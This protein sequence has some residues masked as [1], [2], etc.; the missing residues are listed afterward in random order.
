MG[1]Y[2]SK[3]K[4]NFKVNIESEGERWT[5][6]KIW[7]AKANPIAMA[8]E[9]KRDERDLFLLEKHRAQRILKNK[10]MESSWVG[11]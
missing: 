1:F 9:R 11:K 10:A 4:H 7:Q 8:A 3:K 5:K 6:E 2:K